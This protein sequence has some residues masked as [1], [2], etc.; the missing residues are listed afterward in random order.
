MEHIDWKATETYLAADVY[1]NQQVVYHQIL[2]ENRNLQE[3]TVSPDIIITKKV[4]LTGSWPDII[5]EDMLNA[6]YI[7]ER[8]VLYENELYVVYGR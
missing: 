2:G 5:T 4:P 8:T 3:D 1:S 7:E 6:C